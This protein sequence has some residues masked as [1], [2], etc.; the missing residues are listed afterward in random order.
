[1][2]RI[3]DHVARDGRDSFGL[4]QV[5]GSARREADNSG[6]GGPG[7]VKVGWAGVTG[8]VEADLV[9]LGEDVVVARHDGV[10]LDNAGLVAEDFN[11]GRSP[12][13]L[14]PDIDRLAGAKVASPRE[15]R[16]DQQDAVVVGV[17][18]RNDVVPPGLTTHDI[19]GDQAVAH[20]PAQQRRP[21]QPPHDPVRQA[22]PGQGLRPDARSRLPVGRR[23]RRLRDHSVDGTLSP[24]SHPGRLL[25]ASSSFRGGIVIWRGT[26][27]VIQVP[28][29][30]PVPVFAIRK[31]RHQDDTILGQVDAVTWTADVSPAPAPPVGTAF[32]SE[33]TRQNDVLVAEVDGVIVGYA[34]LSQSIALPSHDHVLTLNGLA[35]DPQRQRNG[36]GRRLVEAAIEEA[37]GRGA[38]KLSLRVLG[39]N[40]SARL[41]YEACGFVVEGILRAEFL[42]D[43]RYVDDVLMARQLAP[44]Q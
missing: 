7:Q 20:D 24:S 6:A 30:H 40:T 21:Q 39:T 25:L 13:A 34:K 33:R 4:S 32:F 41:L 36:A 11:I 29:R 8:L 43:G 5:S 12:L 42:L 9:E 22:L 16:A 15:W 19:Q 31:A 38:H 23:I 44:E 1:M 10:V 3:K 26:T 27:L 2:A 37:Q 14:E 28:L 18:D 35:V 17:G